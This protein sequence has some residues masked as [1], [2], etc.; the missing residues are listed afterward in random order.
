MA[1]RLPLTVVWRN[2]KDLCFVFQSPCTG[3]PP[4]LHCFS[5]YPHPIPT[6]TPS[7]PRPSPPP[8][9]PPPALHSIHPLLKLS[10]LQFCFRNFSVSLLSLETYRMALSPGLKLS[11][12]VSSTIVQAWLGGA[13]CVSPLHSTL[14][15]PAWRSPRLV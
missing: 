3:F 7:A 13:A 6:P 12:T 4:F 11:L 9:P 10:T 1:S 15:L 14:A 2:A 8:P 5:I